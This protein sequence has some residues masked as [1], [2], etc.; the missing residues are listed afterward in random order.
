MRYFSL[1]QG[2][3]YRFEGVENGGHHVGLDAHEGG[4]RRVYERGRCGEFK[5]QLGRRGGI[6]STK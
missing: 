6:Q 2:W 4:G 3:I 5:F 1:Q